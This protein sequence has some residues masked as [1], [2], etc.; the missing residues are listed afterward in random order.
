MVPATETKARPRQKPLPAPN[1]DLYQLAGTMKVD[2][3]SIV[4][5]VCGVVVASLALRGIE[6]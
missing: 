2:D 6:G 1:R 5:Q 4:K 3:P